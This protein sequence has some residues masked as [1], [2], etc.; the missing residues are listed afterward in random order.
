VP[1][2]ISSD[3]QRLRQVWSNIISNAIK[4]TDAGIVRVTLSVENQENKNFLVLSV[5]D[6]GIGIA[7][8]ELNNLFNAY[9][10]VELG[11]RRVYGGT[12]LGLAISKELMELL[13]GTISVQSQLN[14]GSEFKI[15]TPLKPVLG[16][17]PVN[18]DEFIE[19]SRPLSILVAEDNI[20]NQKVIH[21]LL[22]KMGHSVVIV[23]QGDRAV[24][25]RI[26][27]DSHFDIVLMDCE[28]PHMDGYEATKMIREYEQEH[29]L[30][31]IPI[32]ALTAHAL[33]EVRKRCLACGM[34]DFLTKPI[35]TNQLNRSLQA[36]FMTN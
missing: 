7:A 3:S 8:N 35:N 21:G 5:K 20:V 14:Q 4:F 31:N 29:S 28:M 18:P 19:Q 34:N 22:S 12:G 30:P 10:Q 15:W 36:I 9:Q 2:W 23:P 11:K 26:N 33:E 32:V 1:K 6:S 13:G 25:E 16:L 24:S 17:S 27:P